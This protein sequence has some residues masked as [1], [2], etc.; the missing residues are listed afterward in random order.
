[1]DLNQLLFE[2][3]VALMRFTA[4]SDTVKRQAPFCERT[5]LRNAHPEPAQGN[6]RGCL[7]AARL[8]LTACPCRRRAV[9]RCLDRQAIKAQCKGH[10]TAV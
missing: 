7:S 4:N 10:R 1:M 9:K 5:P 3:Q 8:S 6:G 2:H